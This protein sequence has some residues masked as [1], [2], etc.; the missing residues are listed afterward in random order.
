VRRKQFAR[1][2]VFAALT[3]HP[4]S[5]LAD[6]KLVID[7]PGLPPP[8][9]T[10]PP[11]PPRSGEGSRSAKTL[12]DRGAAHGGS[13]WRH[14]GGSPAPSGGGGRD[15]SGTTE[16][17]Q[18]LANRVGRLGVTVGPVATITRLPQP[19]LRPLSQVPAGTYLAVKEERPGWCAVLMV[20]GSIGWIPSQSV[21]LLDY[22]IVKNE[23]AATGEPGPPDASGLGGSVLREAYRLLGVRYVWGG[24]GASGIDCS[25]LVKACFGRCGIALPRR[26][27]EQARVGTPVEFAALQPGD[28]LYFAVKGDRID[29]TGIY[30]G[31]GYFIHSSMSRGA[32]GVDR[33]SRPL[34]HRSL[35]AARRT[36]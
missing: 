29:H 32:V 9:K 13:D 26:A 33:L 22:D 21:R 36:L 24:N 17:Y 35:V 12:G 18:R 23:G 7:L 34:Y 16:K 2:A 20:D 4:L 14:A 11:A 1:L 5:C 15:G 28:R 10:S 27:S 6:G 3:L 19:Y 31:N 25:G 30:V 8:V